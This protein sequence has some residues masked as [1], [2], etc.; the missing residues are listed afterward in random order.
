MNL[1]EEK[2]SEFMAILMKCQE[3]LLEIKTEIAEVRMEI[4]TEIAEVRMEYKQKNLQ[5]MKSNEESCNKPTSEIKKSANT[6]PTTF[7]REIIN[8][9]TTYNLTTNTMVNTSSFIKY[10][11]SSSRYHFNNVEHL[12]DAYY[13]P[14]TLIPSN[15]NLPDSLISR[16]N[17]LFFNYDNMLFKYLLLMFTFL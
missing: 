13:H 14:V 9:L 7:N 8:L 16:S 3:I 17:A 10:I 15:N 6:S 12:F 11:N 5:K 2:R 4:K 1:S